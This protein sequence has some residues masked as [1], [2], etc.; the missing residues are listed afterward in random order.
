MTLH[1]ANPKATH[2]EVVS[3]VDPIP[4]EVV[5]E[6]VFQFWKELLHTVGD[7]VP[8]VL[9]PLNHTAGEVDGTTPAVRREAVRTGGEG[10]GVGVGVNMEDHAPMLIPV[11]PW[12]GMEVGTPSAAGSPARVPDMLVANSPVSWHVFAGN[13][14]LAT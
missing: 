10:D 2:A 3:A 7:W 6:A 11:G 13:R 4:A 8:S 5:G 9:D 1:C 14:N 12:T